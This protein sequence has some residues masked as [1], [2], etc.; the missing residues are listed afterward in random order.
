MAIALTTPLR[1][2]GSYARCSNFIPKVN[3]SKI[4]SLFFSPATSR[5]VSRTHNTSV[6]VVGQTLRH[7]KSILRIGGKFLRKIPY[8][9]LAIG[10]GMDG[11]ELYKAKKSG[12]K[13]EFKKEIKGVAIEWGCTAIGT[14]IGAAI[15]AACTEGLG[16]GVG[17]E[18]G[19]IVGA[20]VGMMLRGK[21]FTERQEEQHKLLANKKSNF[22]KIGDKNKE[23][24]QKPLTTSQML[25]TLR[26]TNVAG[27]YCQQVDD[28]GG[29]TKQKHYFYD[30]DKNKFVEI[31]NLYYIKDLQDLPPEFLS[32]F[33]ASTQSYIA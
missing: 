28:N 13:E 15:G 18:I 5:A 3:S 10:I 17:A 8:I 22:T 32:K 11:Y 27:I 24:H 33:L 16:T 31:P 14:G 30:F 25:S 21:T 2:D 29:Y 6:D 4:T 23:N 20:V 7:S 1:T 19:G 9:G 12:S 26:C